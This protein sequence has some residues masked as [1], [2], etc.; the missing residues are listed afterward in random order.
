MSR[1]CSI[2]TLDLSNEWPN[3]LS[4][5]TNKERQIRTISQLLSFDLWQLATIEKTKNGS[6]SNFVTEIEQSL[7]SLEINICA[8]L[9]LKYKM[10]YKECTAFWSHNKYRVQNAVQGIFKIKNRIT[11]NYLIY[12]IK[13]KSNFFLVILL[14]CY[15]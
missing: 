11:K 7:K 13:D 14:K 3:N 9:I 1:L 2:H 15:L 10:Q 5:Q 12:F 8:R 4:N 6:V